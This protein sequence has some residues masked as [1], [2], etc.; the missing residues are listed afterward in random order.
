MKKLFLTG[1]RG[2]IG[3]A[4]KKVFEQSGYSVIAPSSS[5]LNLERISEIKDYFKDKENDFSAIVHCAGFNNPK[6]FYDL[7]SKDVEKAAKINYL[8]FFELVKVLSPKMVEKKQGKI[9]A[10]S[11]LYGSVARV[12]RLAYTSS[13]HALNGCVQNLALELAKDN[14]LVNCVSPGF[15]N[16]KMTMKNNSEEK[17]K[18]MID[19]IPVK[20]LASVEEI[21]NAVYF[22]CSDS[23]SYITG[24][25]IVVDGG[26]M[27][28]GGQ[29]LWE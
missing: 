5:E 27:A 16:T 22:L 18:Q 8:S 17:I 6:K 20:R 1:A 7:T 3:S 25:N 15:V 28:S 4:I 11:S 14:V 21:A 29:G 23:N 26:F 24:Q 10:V 9:V 13:K 19:K 12:G 2:D